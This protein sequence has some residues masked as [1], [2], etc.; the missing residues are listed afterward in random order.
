MHQRLGSIA[1]GP[2]LGFLPWAL[3]SLAFGLVLGSGAWL[4]AGIVLGALLAGLLL[5]SGPWWLAM[6]WMVLSPTIAVFLNNLLQGIPFFRTERVVFLLLLGGFAAQVI[7]RKLRLAP[8]GPAERCM[9][10]FLALALAHV[11]VSLPGKPL[12][13][14]SKEDGAL[15]FD[16]YLMPMGAFFIARRLAWT[17]QRVRQFLALL[18]AAALFLALTA[19]LETLLGIRWFIPTYLDVIHVLLRATGTFGN[20]AAYGAVM[21]SLLLLVALLCT[22]TP[23][24]GWRLWWLAVLLAVLAAIVLSKTRAA[25]VG[26]AAGLAVVFLRDARSRPMLGLLAAGVALAAVVAVPWLLASR[27]FEERVLDTAP[28][29][30][31]I[32]G[33]GAALNM[34]LSN[35][36][37]GVGFTR[38]GFGL[39]RGQ[40][41]VEVGEVSAAWIRELAVPHNEFLNVGAMMGL[42]G[43]VLYL[44]V[45]VAVFRGLRRIAQDPAQADFTRSLAVY[46]TALWV[47]WCINACFADFANLGYVNMLLYFSAGVVA[48]LAAAPAA[49]A[50]EPAQRGASTAAM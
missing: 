34:M 17:P 50:G 44:R 32:A 21:G 36:L 19:P 27:G 49:A 41:A 48:A 43:F 33:S 13:V 22:T 18:G 1:W 4:L 40:Y 39:H 20:A 24:G 38:A 42:L 14:W 47:G 31:R 3:L 46:V 2:L 5:A 25:W 26:V 35:P 15:L 11:L 9:A 23:P 45:F 30:N 12:G 16:G 6:G 10:A 8:L 29:Y 28:I 7:F 37:T